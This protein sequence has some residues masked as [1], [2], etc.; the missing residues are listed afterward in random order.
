MHIA[1]SLNN[2]LLFSNQQDNGT[3]LHTCLN[4]YLNLCAHSSCVA[5]DSKGW[6]NTESDVP[7]N[8]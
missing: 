4:D 2:N 8:I 1:S 3:K 7:I 6:K 5:D